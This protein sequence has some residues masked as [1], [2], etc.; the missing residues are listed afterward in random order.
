M[1]YCCSTKRVKN[2][3]A[4]QDWN[5]VKGEFLGIEIESFELACI[6]VHATIPNKEN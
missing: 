4:W 6:D 5:N 2:W 3:K 1:E